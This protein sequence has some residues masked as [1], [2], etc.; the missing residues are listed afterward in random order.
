LALAVLEIRA[1]AFLLLAEIPGSIRLLIHS[2][3]QM[4][5]L[6]EAAVLLA[7]AEVQVL[8]VQP[9]I[10]VDPDLDLAA[11]AAAVELVQEEMA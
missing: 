3:A 5:V 11:A 8:L 9:T 7:A 6:A 10:K 1:A 2:Q 4:D